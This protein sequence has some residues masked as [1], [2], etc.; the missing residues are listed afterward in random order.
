MQL[1]SIFSALGDSTRLAIVERLLEDG[2][3]SA[4]DLQD[5][6]KIS[7]PAI[8]RH[9]RVLRSAGVIHQRV[10]KQR[11]FYSVNPEAFQ[12]ISEWIINHKE[13]WQSILDGLAAALE[14]EIS[15]K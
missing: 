3:L 10:D 9:L 12:A 14:E 7:A 6:G 8:S 11:R 2:E 1:V 5:T 4:G 15:K 13:F